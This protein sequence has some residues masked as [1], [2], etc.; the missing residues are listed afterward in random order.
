MIYAAD[1]ET[2]LIGPGNVI[3]KLI[4]L[5][6]RWSGGSD[7]W[8]N[9][10]KDLND[11]LDFVCKEPNSVFVFHNASFDLSVIARARP[12]LIPDIFQGLEDGRFEDTLL[13]EKLLNLGTHGDLK[14]F[15]G[16]KIGYSLAELGKHYLGKDRTSE[17][18]DP[19][20]WRLNYKTLDG[21][22]SSEWPAD[23]LQYAK[24]DSEDTLAIWNGQEE[25]RRDL[26]SKK[27]HDLF[28]TQAFQVAKDFCLKLMGSWGMLVDQEAK[29]NIE[30]W[31]KKELAPEKSALLVSSGVLRPAIPPRPHKANP[32][33]ITLGKSESIDTEVL[34]A[35]VE[36]F[37]KAKGITVEHTPTGEV[38]CR[39]E[40]FEE[41]ADEDPIFEQYRHRQSLQKLITTE[42][43]RMSG[44]VV[45][46]C[47]NALVSS[48]RT[49]SFADKLYP[50]FNVQNVHPRVRGCFIPRPGYLLF[51]IDYAAMELTTLAQTCFNLF[52]HSTLKDLI[53]AGIDPHAFLGARLALVLDEK[54]GNSLEESTAQAVFDAFVAT[55]QSD[56][57]FYKHWRTFAKP[58][59][60]GFPGGLGPETFCAYAKATYGVTCNKKTA[61]TLRDTWKN[62]FPEM[63]E[64]LDWVGTETL[65]PWNKD[66]H[67]YISPM[68]LYCAGTGYCDTANGKA[69]QTPSAEGAGLAV[70]NVVR[71]VFDQSQKSI[72]ADDEKGP[73]V[74]PIGFIHDEILGEVR[75]DSQC[76]ARV[77][78]ITKIMVQS[79]KTIT[80]DVEVKAQP[81]LMRRWNKSA[82]AVFDKDGHLTVWEETS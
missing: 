10:D 36:T 50:S 73:A 67:F 81:V 72:L 77:N 9:G 78:E 30:E 54:F 12:D 4:C 7:L 42:L 17:K 55:K 24:E 27:G 39:A 40:F 79:F 2:D 35:M 3:P 13:R 15:N 23:A 57:A 80:P 47:Y 5:S 29:R 1:T 52:G 19:G 11:A 61:E 53:N 21:I 59:G 65:D 41:H 82:E 33:K 58:T 62:T 63:P 28:E 70:I 44:T 76:E 32:Q 56:P 38:S 16:V 64:Y 31:L 48:G 20:G 18:S 25:E 14:F 8:S 43:P 69:L 22:K 34:K 49:S 74:R 68:G 37:C 51:S 75:E 6:V 26:Y 60:L 66:R 71:A 46:P 45:H